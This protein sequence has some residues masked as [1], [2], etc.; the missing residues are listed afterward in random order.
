MVMPF[1]SSIAEVHG[2]IVVVHHG[3]SR[4]LSAAPDRCVQRSAGLAW[5]QSAPRAKLAGLWHSFC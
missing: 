3:V 2:L 1:H 4:P 5:H